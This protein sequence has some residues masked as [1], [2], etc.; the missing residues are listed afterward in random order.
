MK[1]AFFRGQDLEY[2]ELELEIGSRKNVQCQNPN[3]K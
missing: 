1:T 2:L 3:E